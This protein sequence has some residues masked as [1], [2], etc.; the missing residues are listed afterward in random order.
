MQVRPL[1]P[2]VDACSV[3][4]TLQGSL[5]VEC[6]ARELEGL[7]KRSLFERLLE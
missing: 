5:V 7:E 1:E 4:R 3:P 2:I 6:S